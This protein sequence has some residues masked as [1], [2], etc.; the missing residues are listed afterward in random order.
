MRV[1]P[2]AVEGEGVYAGGG[3]FDGTVNAFIPGL[4]GRLVAGDGFD[5]GLTL[6]L[7]SSCMLL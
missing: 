2:V 7:R 5:I 3:S 4:S 1:G 6:L